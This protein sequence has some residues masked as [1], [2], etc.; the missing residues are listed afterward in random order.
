MILH[1]TCFAII[2][3]QTFLIIKL[4]PW[5][6]CRCFQMQSPQSA[7]ASTEVSGEQVSNQ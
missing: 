3:K 6:N 7:A 4:Y 1:H 2:L 5:F